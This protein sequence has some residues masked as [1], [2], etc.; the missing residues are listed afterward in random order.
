MHRAVFD[1]CMEIMSEKLHQDMCDLILPG[2]PVADV[3]PALIEKNVPQYLRYAC[4]YWVDHLDKLSGDQR[5][6]VGLNDDGKVY[7]FLAE[8]LL[9]WL[10][11]MSLIQETPT[12]ILILNRLQGLINSTRNHLLAALVYDAQRF[13][14]RY[15]WII[16]RAPLQIY[17][18]ALIFSPMR[19]RVRSLFEGLIPSWITKNSNPIEAVTFSPHNN[20]ILASTSCDGTLRIVTTQD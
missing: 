13:L 2:K 20:A 9:F 7:A 6:E 11:T 16:E 5:E 17:C 15:R 1:R 4:R 3:A 12:M 14:L 10:E 19:S 18:S 8:K